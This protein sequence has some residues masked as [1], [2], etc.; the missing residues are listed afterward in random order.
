MALG[1][2]GKAEQCHQLE[3]RDERLPEENSPKKK[4]PSKMSFHHPREGTRSSAL[5]ISKRRMSKKRQK[6]N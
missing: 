5:E 3:G 4:A 6:G 1:A 2:S